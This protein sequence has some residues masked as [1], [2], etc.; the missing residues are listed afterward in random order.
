LMQIKN[1]KRSKIEKLRMKKK[2][3]KNFSAFFV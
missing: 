3:E 2:A 1:W